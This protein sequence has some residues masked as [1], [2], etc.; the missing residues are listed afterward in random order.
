MAAF[1]E[2][3]GG[4]QAGGAAS[5]DSHFFAGALFRRFGGSIAFF[6]GIFN[7]GV[8]VFLGGNGFAV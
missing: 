2:L 5:Y 6:V 3:V 7:D 1:V 4:C 8:F